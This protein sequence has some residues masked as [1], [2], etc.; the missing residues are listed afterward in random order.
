MSLQ[1]NEIIVKHT[2]PNYSIKILEKPNSNVNLFKFILGQ[3]TQ[4]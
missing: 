4:S 1:A 2:V 3:D